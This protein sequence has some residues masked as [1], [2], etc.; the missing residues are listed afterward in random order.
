VIAAH[1]GIN[2]ALM[3][4]MWTHF[5]KTGNEATQSI[6]RMESTTKDNQSDIKVAI[7]RIDDYIKNQNEAQR[8]S[9]NDQDRI[10]KKLEEIERSVRDL[11]INVATKKQQ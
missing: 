11:Q 8:R 4:I 6:D 7:T 10:I 2:G 9:E 5:I 3:S 1:I